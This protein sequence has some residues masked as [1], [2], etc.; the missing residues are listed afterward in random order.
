[1]QIGDRVKTTKEWNDEYYKKGLSG[2]IL[3]TPL[4]GP[5]PEH[6]ERNKYVRLDEPLGAFN[7]LWFDPNHLE[8]EDG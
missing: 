2:M 4:H 3:Q 8:L 7:N 6:R 1:M 5:S